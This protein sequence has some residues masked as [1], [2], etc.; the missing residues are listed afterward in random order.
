MF[1]VE[2]GSASYAFHGY[3]DFLRDSAK[4]EIP[5]VKIDW[6]RLYTG[7]EIIESPKGNDEPECH[8]RSYQTTKTYQQSSTMNNGFSFSAHGIKTSSQAEPPSILFTSGK[9]LISSPQEEEAPAKPFAETVR[10]PQSRETDEV[11][12]LDLDAF[13]KEAANAQ[14]VQEKKIVSKN[15][16][17]TKTPQKAPQKAPEVVE[18]THYHSNFQSFLG[19]GNKNNG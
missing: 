14:P 17:T 2:A 1:T 13:V 6:N 12:G 7:P 11:I 10:A 19:G 18:D 4:K 3:T 8:I 15:A 9:P 16:S 5:A